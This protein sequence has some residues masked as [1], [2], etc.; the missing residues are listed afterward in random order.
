M[1]LLCNAAPHIVPIN[2]AVP[3]T[4]LAVE[5]ITKAYRHGFLEGQ[6]GV[7]TI[8]FMIE[9]ERA[10]I[11][12]AD[13]GAGFEPAAGTGSMGGQL[14]EAFAQQLNGVLEIESAPSK[15]TIVTLRYPPLIESA[16]NE[17]A[18]KI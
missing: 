2:N 17:R 3:L 9:G 16:R 1:Q 4:L 7:I 15:G 8:S 6:N 5:A 14:I 12:I 18:E 11:S 13:N 10:T